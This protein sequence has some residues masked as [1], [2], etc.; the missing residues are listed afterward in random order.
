MV[1]FRLSAEEYEKF[2]EFCFTSGIR[3][4][5]EMARVAI[6][7]LLQEPTR[8]G[9]ESLEARVADLEGRLHILALDMK[10]LVQQSLQPNGTARLSLTAS[11]G[12]DSANSGSPNDHVAP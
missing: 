2:R 11:A 4:V 6:N 3:S 5:S 1:S 10:R 9:H 7:T 12:V 8:A